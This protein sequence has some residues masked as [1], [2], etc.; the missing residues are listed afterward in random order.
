MRRRLAV[1]R[2]GCRRD[3]GSGGGTECAM[4]WRRLDTFG[5]ESQK[6]NVDSRCDCVCEVNSGFE[7]EFG[8]LLQNLTSR[9]GT[10]PSQLRTPYLPPHISISPLTPT[11]LNT[12]SK[13]LCPQ[14]LRR[15]FLPPS[16]LLSPIT[17][18]VS[19]TVSRQWFRS[20]KSS[21]RDRSWSSTF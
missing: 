8:K 19:S 6:E 7:C 4:G 1:G 14:C 10:V 3:T 9:P 15:W 21:S 17:S 16:S 12:S 5:G 18:T 11:R 20:A 2:V 13:P